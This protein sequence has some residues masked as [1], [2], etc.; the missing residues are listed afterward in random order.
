MVVGAGVRRNARGVR[1][2][3]PLLNGT[4]MS[5]DR[6]QRVAL[7][8]LVIAAA[9]FLAER[10]FVVIGFLASPLL[11]FGLAWLIALVLQPVVAWVTGLS[12]PLLTRRPDTRA[13]LAAVPEWHVSRALAVLLVYL[14]LFALLLVIIL[15]LVPAIGPQLTGLTTAMPGGV[16]TLAGWTA[17]LQE[18][19]RRLGFRGDLTTIVQ[20]TAL[21]EQAASIGSTA[22]QQSLGIAGSLATLV[23][24]VSL[25]LILSFYI[26]LD[27]PR[28][29]E[30]I[31]RIMPTNLREETR[32]FF[33]IV[34][35]TFGGFLRAQLLNSLLYGM[36]TAIV[37]GVVG[38]NDVAL[39]SVLSGLLVLIPLVGGIFALIPPAFIAVV[40]APSRLLPVLAGLIIIQQVLFNVVMP[41]LVGQIIG[42]HPL[43]VFAALLVGGAVAGGWGILFGIPVAGVIASVSHYVYL[44]A[45]GEQRQATAARTPPPTPGTSPGPEPREQPPETVRIEP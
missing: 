44:R 35:R 6:L 20:P 25:V 13:G 42:L 15:A 7:W 37:M 40:E 26:T 9:V 43:L 45:S 8:L 36:A 1:R 21:A 31:L 3:R 18:S 10:L 22:I 30:Q 17:A 4:T 19:L 27:G 28:V 39:A 14:A 16:E 5:H 24:N 38:L 11:L 29:G 32:T 41:R 34:D 23:F 2:E 33:E 12:L